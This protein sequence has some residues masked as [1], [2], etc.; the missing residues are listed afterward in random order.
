MTSIGFSCGSTPSQCSAS[1]SEV[2]QQAV[3]LAGL[4]VVR[5]QEDLLAQAGAAAA[6]A[7][8]GAAVLVDLHDVQV[9][10]AARGVPVDREEHVALDALRGLVDERQ[11]RAALRAALHP[12]LAGGETRREA[13]VVRLR[14]GC[15]VELELL[16]LLAVEHRGAGGGQRGRRDQGD[17]AGDG[18]G[19]S[20]AGAHEAGS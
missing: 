18:G 12:V 5:A 1:L 10:V 4:E 20:E 9:E 13:L 3:R 17:R 2:G 6:G 11:D 19:E 16:D 14:A 7:D 15:R 8:L